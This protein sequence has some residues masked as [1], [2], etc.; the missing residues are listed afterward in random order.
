M[1]FVIQRYGYNR[2]SSPALTK[3]SEPGM[4]QRM[5]LNTT[6]SYNQI[7]WIRSLPGKDVGLSNRIF[8][9]VSSAFRSKN[10]E[11][12]LFEINSSK[13]LT[14]LLDTLIYESHFGLKPF[15]HL[16]MHGDKG[17][18]LHIAKTN[19]FVA[20]SLISKKLR[21]VNSATG[22]NLCIIGAACYGLTLLKHVDLRAHTPFYILLAP[23][24]KVQA[25]F[26]E[27]NLPKFYVEL[28]SSGV[29]DEVYEKH[30]AS[31]FNYFHSEKVLAIHLANYIK[32]GCIGK[33]AA[34]RRERLLTEM[35][36]EGMEYTKENLQSARK[37]LKAGLKPNQELL[38]RYAAPFLGNRTCTLKIDELLELLE[39]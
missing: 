31:R 19:E 8:D 12:T 24:K 20:W 33:P 11:I 18:G 5:Q 30:L 32:L 28:L 15:L 34:E 13:D 29:I 3:K 16:D 21:T 10:R 9:D 37:H 38:E 39:S 35:L 6:F 26:L 27:D 2:Q 1:L 4:S 7:F 14:D 17:K 36:S 23:E 25:G 22:N